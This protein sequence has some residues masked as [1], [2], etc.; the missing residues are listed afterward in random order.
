MTGEWIQ[1]VGV[2]LGPTAVGKTELAIQ[3]VER[4]ERDGSAAE[5]INA[6]SRQIYRGMDIG[7]AKPTSQQRQRAKHHLLDVVKP[8]EVLGLAEYLRLVR[9]TLVEMNLRAVIPILVGGTGQY[10]SAFLEDWRIPEVPPQPSFRN[11]LLQLAKKRGV[12][13]LHDRLCEF[14]HVAAQ[15]IHPNN[16]RRVIRALEVIEQTG[17]PF[18]MQQKKGEYRA[19]LFQIGLT[20][21]RNCVHDRADRRLQLM[22]EQG[23]VDEVRALLAQGYTPELPSFSALGYR[24]MADHVMGDLTLDEALTQTKKATHR[25]V[26]RQMS[27]FRNHFSQVNWWDW[28]KP[29][30]SAVYHWIQDAMQ[31]QLLNHR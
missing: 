30:P 16:V 23:F 15:K 4:L 24:E 11:E 19:T 10:L 6:D 20:L 31:S 14:D 8:D 1:P 22:L 12:Q 2:I 3:L 25:F 5:I 17:E 7:T 13:S 27:W 18:S 21:S 29:D 26:R 28:S 9:K